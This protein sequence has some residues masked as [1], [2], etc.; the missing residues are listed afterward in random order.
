MN[1]R[2]DK[3]TLFVASALIAVAM[4]SC[5]TGIESTPKITANDV[6]KQKIAEKPEDSY[7]SDITPEPFA[8][9]KHG[10]RF[11]V[12]D[13]KFGQLLQ[14]TDLPTD[15][16][17]GAM[18][19][20]DNW[21]ETTN[22]TGSK[23]VEVTFRTA[24]GSP[25]VYRSTLS[26]AELGQSKPLDIPFLTELDIIDKLNE[27]LKGKE[28]HIITST[29]FDTD[30]KPFTGRNFV[31]VKIDS[32]LPGNS[33]FTSILK[34]T[35]ENGK[36]F[37]LY[38]TTQTGINAWRNFGKLFSLSNPRL[39]YPQITDETWQRI[40]NGK[41]AIGMT[42]SECRLALGNPKSV[43]RRAGYS[44]IQEV[45]SYDYGYYLIFE[46]NALVSFRQ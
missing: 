41:V 39:A 43:D 23:V 36:P 32:V 30:M 38:M 40:I 7:I 14:P 29:W 8:R 2:F 45:W 27:R 46:D 19:T 37:K 16:L 20:F 12:N 10:K 1:I 24:Q 11:F 6:K 34:L 31:P 15:S 44:S 3:L 13:N 4:N 9:W 18:I 22:Y 17:A 21:N 33:V 35:D 42:K 25:L 28:F 26:S 5:F